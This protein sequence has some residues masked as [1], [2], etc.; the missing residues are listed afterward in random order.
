M[1]T[2]KLA[3][4][5]F[6]NVILI[7]AASDNKPP[8]L[9]EETSTPRKYS[10]LNERY[11]DVGSLFSDHY[12]ENNRPHWLISFDGGGVKALMHLLA[13]EKFENITGK[14][15]SDLVD[16]ISGTSAGG[17]LACLL[18]MRDPNTLRPK[19]SAKELLDIMLPTRDRMFVRRWQSL[20]GLLGPRYSSG[21]LEGYFGSLFG[22]D[23]FK[24]RALPVVLVAHDLNSYAE[25]LISTTDT[26]DFCTRDLVAAI[27]AA[28]TFFEP[29]MLRSASSPAVSHLLMDG[30]TVMD[31][32]VLA[33]ISLLQE[34]YNV[35]L[36]NINV[37]SFGTGISS[38]THNSDDLIHSGFLGWGRKI[39]GICREGQLS[40]IDNQAK[41]YLKERYHRFQPILGEGNLH[42][43][44]TSD[45]YLSLLKKAQLQMLEEKNK[46]IIKLAG[47]LMK[48]AQIRKSQMPVMVKP[49]APTAN[50]L[51]KRGYST[52]A[53]GRYFSPQNFQLLRRFVFRR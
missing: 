23:N 1:L 3:C 18:T 39:V 48:V 45:E 13:V 25:R 8:I 21:P 7:L 40:T 6:I 44:D 16:G 33:G 4:L 31:N 11:R 20:W 53:S 35:H 9:S 34:R 5:I 37:L 10:C 52:V 14:P 32:P 36:R 22:D 43:A 38:V 27:T 12:H 17:A 46:E 41:F 24:S 49:Q 28:P 47:S 30:A 26:S 51:A 19:Y 15:I 42:L 2:S 50:P 29:K